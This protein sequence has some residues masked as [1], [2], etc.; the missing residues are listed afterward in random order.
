M[1]ESVSFGATDTEQTFT[2]AVTDDT[3]VDACES[4]ALSFGT[5]PAGVTAGT[6]SEATVTIVDNDL[7]VVTIAAD[8]ELRTL[9]SAR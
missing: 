8:R 5:M 4:V 7:P 3:D 1:L 2:L 6:P 9:E